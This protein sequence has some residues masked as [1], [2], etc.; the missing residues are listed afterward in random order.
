VG[1]ASDVNGDDRDDIIVGAGWYDVNTT[2][3]GCAYVHVAL[4]DAGPPPYPGFFR[5]PMP[6]HS[7]PPAGKV[8]KT[9]PTRNWPVSGRHFTRSFRVESTTFSTQTGWGLKTKQVH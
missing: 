7:D 9:F 4:P 6:F 1:T 2:D 8:Y 5:K 3:E